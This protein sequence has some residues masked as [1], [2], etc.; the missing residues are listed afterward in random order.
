MAIVLLTLGVSI[1]LVATFVA[2]GL[3]LYTG[4][5]LTL[6]RLKLTLLFDPEFEPQRKRIVKDALDSHIRYDH[7][8]IHAE[9][10]KS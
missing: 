3:G 6:N 8:P 10:E 2:F 9:L 5:T 4:K 1:I 7:I